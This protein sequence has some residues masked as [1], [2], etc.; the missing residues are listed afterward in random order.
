MAGAHDV[1][2][3]AAKLHHRDALGH[4]SRR[5]EDGLYGVFFGAI[6]IA[7]IDPTT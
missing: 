1:L 5:G 6:R 2:G 3:G 4:R 7:N